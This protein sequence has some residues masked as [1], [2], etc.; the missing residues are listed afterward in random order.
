MVAYYKI[1]ASMSNILSMSIDDATKSKLQ[2]RFPFQ[3]NEDLLQHLGNKLTPFTGNLFKTNLS[4]TSY[5]NST[6]DDSIKKK[7]SFLGP[8][9]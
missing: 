6:R 2:H 4:S 5:Y 8:V 7:S 1:N 9:D 3:W